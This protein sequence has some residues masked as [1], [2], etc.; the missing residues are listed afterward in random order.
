MKKIKYITF[1]SNEN[2]H[3]LLTS[4]ASLNKS[5]YLIK[6]LNDLDYSIEIITPS[7]LKI[8]K[9]FYLYKKFNEKN[10]TF[11]HFSTLGST[12]KILKLMNLVSCIIQLYFHI[13][14]NTKKN[15][16]ILIYHSV[17]LFFPL[18]LLKKIKK[19]KL[20][21]E[22]EE[23][24]YEV[25][26]QRKIFKKME[27]KL[28]QI[29][30]AYIFSTHTLAKRIKYKKPYVVSY[31]EFNY[32]EQRV[33]K[34]NDGKIHIVYAGT[35]D[36]LKGVIESINSAKFLDEKYHLHIIGFGNEKET[37]NVLGLIERIKKETKCIITYDGCL[38]GDD[39]I[40]FIQKC[41]IGLSTIPKTHKFIDYVFPSKILSYL[42]NNLIVVSS[43]L[44]SVKTSPFADLIY[45]YEKNDPSVIAETIRNIKNFDNVILQ[46][47]KIKNL[48][49]NFTK[50]LLNLI[51]EF[52]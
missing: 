28:L 49:K 46:K 37:N 7:I 16:E 22:V 34:F 10:N 27:E 50:E 29:A 31:G 25:W 35:F 30:D 19:V 36:P 17:I 8:N 45:F 32:I 18:I 24:Y 40:N 23:I 5:K 38:K 33:E 3:Y 12:I 42:C 26:K 47:E 14:F 41:H 52:E 2:T 6:V 1:Y 43:D 48:D 51:N 9:G 11:I 15:E 20:I 21:L 4:P 39:Y 13:Y 44:E